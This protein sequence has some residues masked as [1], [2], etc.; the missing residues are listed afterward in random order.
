MNHITFETTEISELF[1]RVLPHRTCYSARTR[2]FTSAHFP[3][4]VFKAHF[5]NKA[6][7]LKLLGKLILKDRSAFECVFL[8]C[9]SLH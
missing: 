5:I 8:L 2:Y 7:G 3:S 1:P 4:D 6:T 9:I